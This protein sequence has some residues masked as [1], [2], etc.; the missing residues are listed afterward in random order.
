MDTE[1]AALAASSATTIVT[2]LT[3]DAWDQVKQKMTALWRRFKPDQ[4][5]TIG[6]E[7]ARS[8]LEIQNA[9]AATARAS[10]KGGS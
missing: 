9:D 8:R 5:D 4:A 2:L 1:L 3:T 6:V 7:L 10:A